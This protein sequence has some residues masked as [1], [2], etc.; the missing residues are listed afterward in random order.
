MLQTFF[1]EMQ[2]FAHCMHAVGKTST[3]NIK[4][5]TAPKLEDHGGHCV[6]V[7][8]CQP[9]LLVATECTAK[10]TLGACYS[11]CGMAALYVSSKTNTVGKLNTDSISLG[12]WWKIP[13][14]VL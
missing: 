10:N 13:K 7:G 6:F 8:Y 4:T 3:V 1:G 12:N 14:G 11:R 9:I 2:G 5:D